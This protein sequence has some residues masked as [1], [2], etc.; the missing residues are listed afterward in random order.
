MYISKNILCHWTIKSLSP[1]NV[2]DLEN[3][4]SE[5]VIKQGISPTRQFPGSWNCKLL[6]S[7]SVS[8]STCPLILILHVA[9]PITSFSPTIAHTEWVFSVLQLSIF[10]QQSHT[11]ND[12]LLSGKMGLTRG[13]LL[14]ITSLDDGFCFV[15][16]EAVK[17]WNLMSSQYNVLQ[18]QGFSPTYT[19]WLNFLGKRACSRVCE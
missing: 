19:V 2:Y 14:E 5:L 17:W 13:T 12:Y 8:H 15:K 4:S 11:R 10:H 6:P 9:S 3:I 1:L 16:I 7:S 18:F